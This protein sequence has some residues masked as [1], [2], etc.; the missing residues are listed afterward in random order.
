MMGSMRLSINERSNMEKHLE[1]KNYS[2]IGSRS[3][4]GN[5]DGDRAGDGFEISS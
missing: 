2:V 4:G 3:S 5:M 1:Y